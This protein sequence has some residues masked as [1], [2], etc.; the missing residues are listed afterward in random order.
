MLNIYELPSSR[1]KRSSR[2]TIAV[3]AIVAAAVI[4]LGAASIA[5]FDW[6]SI[7]T[8]GHASAGTAQP[9]PTRE[10]AAN[11]GRRYD[12]DY[13]PDRFINQ[14]KEPAEPIATF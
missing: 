8:L 9:A 1:T 3:V 4:V 2:K 14:A 11:D 10:P 6:S 12:F 7:A 13:F 5:S